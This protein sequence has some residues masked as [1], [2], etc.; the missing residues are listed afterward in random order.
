M[1]Q[2]SD[3]TLEDLLERLGGISPRRVL[4]DPPPGTATVKDVIRHRD[5]PR[6]RLVELVDGTLVEKAMGYSE[7]MVASKLV[8][9]LG[10]FAEDV[11]KLGVVTGPDGTIKVLQKLVRIPDVAFVA[12]DR[13]PNRQ[14]PSAKVPEVVPNL[15][16]EVLSEGN[17]R[18]EMERKLKEY[19]LAGVELVWFVDP[20]ERTVTVY[21]SP[22][23]SETLSEKGTLSGGAVLPG[24]AV[25]VAELFASLP[26]KPKKA[27]PAKKGKK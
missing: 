10:T 3:D 9:L 23:E 18:R 19:F 25:P 4:F 24:F 12:W 8:R 14:V 7:S 6:R 13:F 1:P 15:A 11:H 5:G 2:V 17:T 26:P 20:E 16:V 27:G 22:D 21:T